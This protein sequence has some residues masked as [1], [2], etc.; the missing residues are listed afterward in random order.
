MNTNGTTTTPS[1]AE[2]WRDIC[3][4]LV[5]WT[6]LAAFVAQLSLSA[7]NIV[8]L[9][10]TSVLHPNLK[11]ILLSQSASFCI[12]AI[13]HIWQMCI[14]LALGIEHWTDGIVIKILLVFGVV[15]SNFIGHVML[16]ERLI[17]TL[18]SKRYENWKKPH[19][20][21][22]WFIPI[23]SFSLFN[24]LQSAPNETSSP[25]G[26]NVG[27]GIM[28]CFYIDAQS[29]KRYAIWAKNGTHSLSERYQLAQNIRTFRQLA[30]TFVLHLANL[31]VALPTTLLLYYK[32]I[33]DT[34]LYMVVWLTYH[35][36]LTVN[37]GLIEFTLI[38]R[39][40]ILRNETLNFLTALRLFKG[41]NQI[42]TAQNANIGVQIG[43]KNGGEMIEMEKHFQMLQK[44]WA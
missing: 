38:W 28:A 10:R 18:M 36:A 4:K 31:I 11:M 24:A 16:V 41:N 25:V 22:I 43:T 42:C 15:Y 12:F 32:L 7:L 34:K 27:I 20:S 21:L 23:F 19:F 6:N 40:P 5:I 33:L 14:M 39:H 26:G 8:L 1:P 44:E 9:A 35:L 3:I 29:R 17:A 30:P 13:G 37:N 2:D